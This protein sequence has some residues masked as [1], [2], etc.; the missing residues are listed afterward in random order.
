MNVGERRIGFLHPT[1]LVHDRRNVR[2]RPL[3][4]LPLIKAWAENDRKPAYRYGGSA[5]T[6]HSGDKL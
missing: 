5:R 3:P 1:S 4:S 6:A 2:I